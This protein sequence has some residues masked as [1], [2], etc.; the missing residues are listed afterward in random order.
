MGAQDAM[1]DAGSV[2]L[3]VVVTE[4]GSGL[5]A[6][7]EDGGATGPVLSPEVDTLTVC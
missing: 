3:S 2:P 4:D 7:S 1:G 6:G 5:L